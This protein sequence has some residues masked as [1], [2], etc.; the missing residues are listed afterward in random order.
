MLEGVKSTMSFWMLILKSR[1]KLGK[2]FFN[3]ICYKYTH[4]NYLFYNL[5]SHMKSLIDNEAVRFGL[6]R[7]SYGFKENMGW[8]VEVPVYIE[9]K[10]IYDK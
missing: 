4:L 9:E 3:K 10:K 5:S 8:K 2:S 6:E 7:T 1:R